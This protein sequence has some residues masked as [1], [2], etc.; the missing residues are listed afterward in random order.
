LLSP[1]AT[2]ALRDLFGSC[3]VITPNL[4]ELSLLAASS[5]GALPGSVTDHARSLLAVGAR[6]VLVKG[7]HGDGAESIDVLFRVGHTGKSFASPRLM[8]TM[9]GTGCMLSS[10]IV[11]RLAFADTLS[12]AIAQAK[13][14]VHA[15]LR[16][17]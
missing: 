11:A 9:R 13:A 14:F 5:V 4:P 8:A 12:T 16:E 7:G 17:T 1:D 2:N 10:A 3:T 6:A 15:R